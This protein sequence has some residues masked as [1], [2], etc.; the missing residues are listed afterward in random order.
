MSLIKPLRKLIKSNNIGNV[1]RCS[2]ALA[3]ASPS[4]PT[5]TLTSK[6]ELKSKLLVDFE[7]H[8]T[9]NHIKLNAFNKSAKFSHS[10]TLPYIWLR[11]N[12]SCPRCYNQVAAECEVNMASL[13]PVNANRPLEVVDEGKRVKL[14]WRDGH[15][16]EFELTELASLA[17]AHVQSTEASRSRVLWNNEILKS[18]GGL[19]RLPYDG[20]LKD[21]GVLTQVLAAVHKFGAVIIE[22]V[23]RLFFVCFYVIDFYNFYRMINLTCF[24]II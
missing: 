15:N 22:G 1:I 14:V 24:K 16:S 20:Y 2:S 6:L 3:A 21:E 13:D 9:G 4:Q 8:F 17:L 7:V 19:T 5:L 12:C 23:S 18:Q 10:K 11:A